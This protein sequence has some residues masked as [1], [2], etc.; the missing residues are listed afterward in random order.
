[1]GHAVGKW[2]V[3]IPGAS[4]TRGEVDLVAQIALVLGADEIR[5]AIAAGSRSA[6]R[7]DKYV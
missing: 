3:R 4:V 6:A 1:M 5:D 7:L 2:G